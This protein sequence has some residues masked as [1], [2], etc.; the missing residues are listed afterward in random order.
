MTLI[1]TLQRPTS[2]SRN[3]ELPEALPPGITTQRHQALVA[4]GRWLRE[5]NYRFVTPTPETHRRVN[6]RA[7]SVTARSLADVFGWSRTFTPNLLP[8]E[9][10]NIM[11]AAGVLESRATGLRSQ[12]RVSSIGDLLFLHSAYPTTETDAVFFGPDT[13][14]FV[15]FLRGLERPEP[16]VGRL[17]RI[18]DIG[19]GSGAGAL[20]LVAHWGGCEAVM[21]DINDNALLY[22]TANA[23]INGLSAVAC[24]SDI[25]SGI[26]GRADLIIAN[27]PYLV[28]AAKRSYRHGGGALGFDLSVRIMEAALPRLQIGGR[29]ALYTASAIVNGVDAF[30]AAITPRLN[31]FPCLWRYEEIDPDV[32][33]EELENAPYDRA[34]RIAVVGLVAVRVGEGG[35]A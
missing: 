18:I 31:A 17:S 33:G 12:A 3:S 34:D 2:V 25:L 15:R 9:I 13:Y 20:S 28:D 16:P 30:R 4:L 21:A 32:F 26:E 24:Y 1:Q 7:D 27:P 8:Q 14:R 23:G 19:A 22:A 10:L 29:L 35:I 5:K 6:A 11:A